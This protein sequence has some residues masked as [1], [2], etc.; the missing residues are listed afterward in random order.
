MCTGTGS[1]SAGLGICSS[2][3][4]A[5]R[6]FFDKNMIEWAICSKVS[7]SLIHSER[8]ELIVHSHSFL[9]SDL[10]D[11][12]TL[13]RGN[14]RIVCFLKKLF[15]NCKKTYKKFNFFSELLVF[16]QE[17][18]RLSDL[19]KKKWAICSFT[20]FWW[21]TWA[22]CS[23]SLICHELPER[24]AHSRSFVLS[25][26]S[27]LLTFAHLSWGIWANERWANEQIPNP[28]FQ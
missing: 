1:I 24:F 28:V 12:L 4:W 23:H 19:L 6:S 27:E 2:V 8:P 25:K 18:E 15:K 7:D 3:F 22:N 20:H 14:E 26:L 10:I 5:N 17:H 11:L 13:L 21:A 9:V 16:C